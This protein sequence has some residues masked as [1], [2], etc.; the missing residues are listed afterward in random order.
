MPVIGDIVELAQRAGPW[1]VMGPTPSPS[2]NPAWRLRQPRLVTRTT[3]FVVE[4]A[5]LEPLTSPTL[6]TGMKLQHQ[7]LEVTVIEDRP[8]EGLVYCGYQRPRTPAG[9]GPNG[10]PVYIAG[11]PGLIDLD[12]G[13]LIAANLDLF[14]PTE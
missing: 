3:A 6:D 9:R 8:N 14:L 13:A 5:A 4:E 10:E 11:G 12:R 2:G 7:G 1:V